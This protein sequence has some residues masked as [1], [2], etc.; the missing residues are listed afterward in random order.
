MPSRRWR[1]RARSSGSPGSSTSSNPAAG[2]VGAQRRPPAAE[3]DGVGLGVGEGQAD[4]APLGGVQRE[5]ARRAEVVAAVDGDQADPGLLGDRHRLLHRPQGD[6]LA[7]A[8]AAVEGGGGRTGPPHPDGGADGDQP[9]PQPLDVDGQ[10][11]HPV[12]GD[13]AQVGGDQ[14]VGHGGGVLLAEPGLQQHLAAE[15]GQRL[16]PHPHPRSRSPGSRPRA[17]GR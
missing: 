2:G 4:H 6:H 14:R 16:R 11:H 10:P 9:A 8:V 1:C 3:G 5:P 15:A 13:P 12:G 17:P 7:G